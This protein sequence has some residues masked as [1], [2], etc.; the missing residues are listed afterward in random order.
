[1]DRWNEMSLKVMSYLSLKAFKKDLQDHLMELLQRRFKHQK[2]SGM[3]ILD[4]M[5]FKVFKNYE[6]LRG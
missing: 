1:M 5:T 3:G 4:L 6:I 2:V